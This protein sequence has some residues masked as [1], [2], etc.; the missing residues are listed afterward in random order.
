MTWR[1]DLLG[2]LLL[3]LLGSILLLAAGSVTLIVL[4]GEGERAPV[5]FPRVRQVGGIIDLMAGANRPARAA[6]LRAANGVD[7]TVR[8]VDALAPIEGLRRAPRLEAELRRFTFS[9]T[10]VRAYVSPIFQPRDTGGR[11]EGFL[12]YAVGRLPDGQFVTLT[13][14]GGPDKERPRFLNLPASLW[15]GGLAGIVAVLALLLTARET[16]PLRDLARATRRFDGTAVT[17]ETAVDGASDIRRTTIAVADMQARVVSLLGERSLMIGSI[18]HDL[19]TLL[20]RMRLRTATLA[21]NGVRQGLE[22][23][24]DGMDAMLADALAFARGTSTRVRGLVD[25]ADI[26]AA[27]LAEREARDGGT[28]I[29]A[30][31]QDA[32]CLG[33]IHALRRVVANLLDNAVKYGRGK[34]HVSVSSAGGWARLSVEDD[35]PGIPLDQRTAV[36]APYHRGDDPRA[37]RLAGSGLGLAIV[38]QIIRAHGGRITILDSRWGGASLTVE[39]ECPDSRS[40][41]A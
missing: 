3:I 31:L 6:I 39:L 4:H 29:T 16:R 41:S 5:S 22:N 9:S 17:V 23:D 21:D 24:L 11:V 33:D 27:E 2:R 28:V 10:P 1:L 7:L 20:T 40:A 38:Q 35:G 13:T 30:D 26:A 19:R 8:L 18:S 12:A 36:L 15:M 32:P 14:N 34:V 37:R 25:L